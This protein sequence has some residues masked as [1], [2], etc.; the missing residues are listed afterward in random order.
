MGLLCRRAR[1]TT[2]SKRGI[3]AFVIWALASSGKFEF[4]QNVLDK[5]I[6]TLTS[7]ANE[8]DPIIGAHDGTLE[9]KIPKA[10]HPQENRRAAGLHHRPGSGAYFLPGL[11][12]PRLISPH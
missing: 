8:R 7:W 9:F 4:A 2:V 5:T 3:A 6:G 1:Q 12:A 10:A 11:K